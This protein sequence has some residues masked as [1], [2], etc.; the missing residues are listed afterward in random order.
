MTANQPTYSRQW[1]RTLL[2][3]LALG[4]ASRHT[5]FGQEL[6]IEL[7]RADSARKNS[8]DWTYSFRINPAKAKKRIWEFQL[9]NAQSL[10]KDVVIVQST[11]PTVTPDVSPLMPTANPEADKQYFLRKQ[12]VIL[13][14][15][16]APA[17]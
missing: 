14:N 17:N 10:S 9:S 5:S 12:R 8:R 2:L 7:P 3:A 13:K 1:R 4:L 11:M 16:L 6:K 15:P